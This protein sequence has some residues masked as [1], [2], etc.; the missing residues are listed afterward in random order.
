M[1][2]T[3]RDLADEFEENREA[4]HGLTTMCVGRGMG[5]TVIWESLHRKGEDT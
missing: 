4:S 2:R 5:G 3:V 1:P